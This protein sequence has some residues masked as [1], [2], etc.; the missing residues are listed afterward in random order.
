M[1]SSLARAQYAALARMRLQMLANSLRS[2]RGSF[3]LAARIIRTAFFLGVGL[4]IGTGLGVGA[5]QITTDNE[6]RLLPLLFW[7]VFML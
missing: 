1:L 2:K 6:P 5:F 7:P 3:D 4:L